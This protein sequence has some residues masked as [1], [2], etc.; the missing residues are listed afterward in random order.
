MSR[1]P[2]TLSV[3]D[4]RVL[5]A[6]AAD[7][8]E[9]VLPIFERTAPDD[10][11]VRSAID[12]ARRFAEGDLDPAEAVRR[13]GGDAGASARDASTPAAKAAAYA[14]EQAAAVAHMGAHALGAAGYAAKAVVLESDS[15]TDDNLVVRSTARHL[16]AV[17][18]VSAIRALSSLPALGVN[19]SGPLGP[20]RLAMGHVG[21]TIRE[22][23]RL[24]DSD[25]ARQDR[26]ELS[27]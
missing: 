9:H 23:Q 26:G 16:V 14:A 21:D 4:R 13:R 27:G 20:G 12:Q 3:E 19:G 17:A 7:C 18:P 11:R 8:A 10:P 24:V 5:A 6:W 1:S 15:D 2:Q 22:I 25:A